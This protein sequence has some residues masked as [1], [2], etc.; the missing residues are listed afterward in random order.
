MEDVLST[1]KDPDKYTYPQFRSYQKDFKIPDIVPGVDYEGT[2]MMNGSK[3]VTNDEENPG[4][5]VF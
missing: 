2:F 1:K 4:T 5:L 3:M